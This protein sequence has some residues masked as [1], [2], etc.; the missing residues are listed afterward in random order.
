MGIK[1]IGEISG[2]E[3]R[4]FNLPVSSGVVIEPTADGPADKAG[5][6]RYD[7]VSVLDG[8]KIETASQLQDLIFSK[9]IGQVVK[10]QLVRL[11][12]TQAGQMEVKTIKVK[13]DK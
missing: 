13:L 11:P 8:E 7:I 4:Y 12:R 9:K 10:L 5:I 3:A 2:D 6:K 1:I